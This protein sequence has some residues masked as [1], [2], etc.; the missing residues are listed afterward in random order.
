MMFC[1]SYGIIEWNLSQYFVSD[2]GRGLYICLEKM[3]S[4]KS[5][6]VPTLYLYNNLQAVANPH[7]QSM[8]TFKMW[9]A[10]QHYSLLVIINY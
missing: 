1:P 4:S 8:Y 6:F 10:L 3:K 2:I 5:R 9:V 7:F